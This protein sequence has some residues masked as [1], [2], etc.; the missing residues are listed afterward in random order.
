MSRSATV[1]VSSQINLRGNRAYIRASKQLK[2][3]QGDRGKPYRFSFRGEYDRNSVYTSD[4]DAE[5]K[6]TKKESNRSFIEAFVL[7]LLKPEE[8]LKNEHYTGT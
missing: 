2:G 6:N 4:R 7:I 1:R 5:L 3:T 8:I